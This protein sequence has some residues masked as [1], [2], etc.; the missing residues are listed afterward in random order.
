MSTRLPLNPDDLQVMS[1]STSVGA[2]ERSIQPAGF[3]WP[4]VC[5]CINICQPTEDIYCSGGCP[6]EMT[7]MAPE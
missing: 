2:T 4:A 1:F 3:S 5:T 7:I 6:P